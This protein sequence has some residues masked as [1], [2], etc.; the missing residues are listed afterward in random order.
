M[1]YA[2]VALFY[3]VG[4]LLMLLDISQCFLLF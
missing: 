3:F 2:L 1:D 4:Q